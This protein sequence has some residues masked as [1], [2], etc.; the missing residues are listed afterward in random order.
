VLDEAQSP[1]VKSH[2]ISG[3]VATLEEELSS[4]HA[5]AEDDSSALAALESRVNEL[6]QTLVET[7]ARLSENE[8]RLAEKQAELAQAKRKEAAERYQE[9][10]RAREDAAG[11]VAEAAATVLAELEAYDDATK[12]LRQLIDD[13]RAAPGEGVTAPDL[14]DDPEGLRETWDRLEERVRQRSNNKLD[15]ELVEA[16]ARSVMGQAIEGLPEHL[17]ELAHARRR[18]RIKEHLSKI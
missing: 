10:F 13:I 7:K 15:D 5:Q 16:A 3:R 6:Q 11:R 18:A 9:A 1:T 17:R 14:E 2:A 4:L 8:R 12:T